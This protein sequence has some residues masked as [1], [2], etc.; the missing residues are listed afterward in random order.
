MLVAFVLVLGIGYGGFVA[1]SPIVISD[2]LGVAGL[3]SILGLLYTSPGVGALIGTPFAG[4][5]IDQTGGYR[6]TIAICFRVYMRV[7]GV[8]HR[9]AGRRVGTPRA[10]TR[11][12]RLTQL[13]VD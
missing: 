4:W 5:V 1:L 3:G 6:W 9:S 2:R 11:R 12:T 13:T 8:A 10:C 7:G